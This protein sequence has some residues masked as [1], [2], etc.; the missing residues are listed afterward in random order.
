MSISSNSLLKSD[1]NVLELRSRLQR[2]FKL[3]PIK[4]IV[5]KQN[6]SGEIIASPPRRSSSITS[7]PF[8]KKSEKFSTSEKLLENVSLIEILKNERKAF[9]KCNEF[10]DK[11]NPVK[12]QIR[13]SSTKNIKLKKQ[14]SCC[15]LPI[16]NQRHQ[17][18]VID[19]AECSQQRKPSIS[20]SISSNDSVKKLRSDVSEFDL[21][22]KDK[23]RKYSGYEED[24][25]HERKLS[26]P[27][28]NITPLSKKGFYAPSVKNDLNILKSG[29][30]KFDSSI[31][32]S[33]GK[34]LARCDDFELVC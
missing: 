31:F 9:N 26:D 12:K 14:L 29:Y 2:P 23:A 22:K 24:K 32:K 18:N 8:A 6:E 21:S 19:S 33:Q 30:I 13:R 7:I 25:K 4:K 1:I 15:E 5:P 10:F 11:L 34:C 27:I 16:I 20:N 28:N 3:S 17:K